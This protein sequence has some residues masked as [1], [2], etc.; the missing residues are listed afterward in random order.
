MVDWGQGRREEE[1]SIAKRHQETTGV[2]N[3][4]Q[5]SRHVSK[6]IK[7]CNLNMCPFFICRLYLNKLVLKKERRESEDY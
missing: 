4:I 2:M 5:K 1:G 7:S 3:N 6:L